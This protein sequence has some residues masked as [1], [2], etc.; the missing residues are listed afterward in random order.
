MSDHGANV[1]RVIQDQ[2][3]LLRDGGFRVWDRAKRVVHCPLQDEAQLAELIARADVLIEDYAPGSRPRQLAGEQLAGQNAR[4]IVGSITG[5]GEAGPLRDE[6]AIDDLVLARL[7]VLA[8]L[9]G[10]RE[11]P[12]H[13]AHPLP[14]VGAGLLAALGIAAALY[15]REETGVGRRVATSLVAGA[16]LY[17]PKV[18]GEKLQ[19]NV[20][21]TNPFGSAP[22]Y[23]VY[24]CADGEWIQLGCVHPGFI[25]KAAE[26]MG[27]GDVLA[28]PVY[29]KGQSPQTAD[30]DRHLRK[31]V[32]EVMITRPSSAWT[33]D[34]ERLDI[35]FAPAQTN[36]DGMADPQVAHNNMLITLDDP[37]VGVIEAMGSPIKM[38]ATPSMARGPRTD[39][40]SAIA[41]LPAV[42]SPAVL[43]V[44]PKAGALPLA[45]IRVL[46]ITNLIAGPIA[47]RLLADIGADVIKLEPPTGDISRPIGRTYFYSINYAKRSIAVDTG[48]DEGKAVV[49]RIARSCDVVLANLRPGATTRMG[50]GVDADPKI[51]E[52]QISGYGLTGPYAHRPG[53][54]PLAQSL[55]GLER[56]QGGTGNPPSFTSQ[57]APTDFTT[58]TM[59]AL[60][61]VLAL[62][63]RRRRRA[64]G[65]RIEVNL[66]DGGIVLS[67]EWF[68]RYDGRPPRPLADQGQ[69][70]P[71]PF[72]R[73]YACADGYI[74]V[75]ADELDQRQAFCQML[76]LSM[77]LTG[78][79]DGNGVHPNDAAFA[80]TAVA[81]MADLDCAA[82]SRRLA[83]AGIPFAPALPPES[84]VFFHDP[85]T[86]LNGWSVTRPHPTAGALTAVCRYIKFDAT[87]NVDILPTPL[88]G[89][90][91]DA[92]LDEAGFARTEIDDLRRNGLIVTETP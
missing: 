50:L 45:G 30:A 24:E 61:T 88:L 19:P 66:L 49:Q 78:S 9:P 39:K 21:Q 27:I 38:S 31:L 37:V 69:H 62:F 15:A 65:Q 11:G 87:P 79:D 20:F 75:A 80:R 89:E 44:G 32:G 29:G 25:A 10:F 70:G 60:G 71:G 4:L 92:V 41:E 8:G 72:H 54:D 2:A 84:E 5:Y 1:V 18:I 53:I 51:I 91:A 3:A 55:I 74:Y 14:S 16:L 67:S 58:G 59:A 35:P 40:L 34:F 82:A 33:A 83:N 13:A 57:L 47:G 63:A 46:E 23:S 12:I 43:P 76:G 86:E 90:H 68:T 85:H 64:T 81:A 7:G 6:P 42:A 73:L 56:A 17:H 77:P 22:F 52:T 48:S 36:E 28:D 26:L